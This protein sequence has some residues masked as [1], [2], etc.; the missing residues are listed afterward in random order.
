MGI[1]IIFIYRLKLKVKRLE[2][3]LT[4][5]ERVEIVLLSG[6]Q[7]W[8]QRQVQD[9]F[10]D[11]HPERNPVTHS[12]VWK[13]VKKFKETGSVVDKPRVGCPSVGE[14]IRTGV[15]AKFHAHSYWFRTFRTLY[16]KTK[17]N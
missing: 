8:T 7:G 1:L 14:D 5:D 11:R 17:V 15:I 3:A 9:E 10:N 16:R 2:M 4:L 12:A 13:L 6:R